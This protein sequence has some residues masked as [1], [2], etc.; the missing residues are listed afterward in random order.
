METCAVPQCQEPVRRRGWC[1]KHY[2]RWY[3]GRDP[4]DLLR[5]GRPRVDRSTLPRGWAQDDQG[6]WWYYDAKQ[7]TLGE[8]RTCAMCGKTFPFK[9]AM[10]KHQPGLYCSRV[11][12]NKADKPGRREAR[13]GKGRY[14][15][16]QGYVQIQ[17]ARGKFR[18][19]HRLVMEQHLGRS[20]LPTETVHHRNGVKTDNR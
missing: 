5:R 7:R 11:C 14:I 4:H 20:L 18:S 17:V 15:N 16:S 2:M 13:G 8:E 3:R 10:Q 9:V 19:E 1:N 12:A 6:R